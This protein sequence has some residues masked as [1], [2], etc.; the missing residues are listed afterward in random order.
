MYEEA[1]YICSE[2]N[3]LVKAQN[4]KYKDITVMS[5]RMN[6]YIYVFEAAFKKYN[7]PYHLNIKKSVMHTSLM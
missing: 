1:D 2:I 3:R 6:D 7:I 5:R 4:Y